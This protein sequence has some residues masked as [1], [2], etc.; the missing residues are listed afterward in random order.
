VGAFLKISIMFSIVVT[1]VSERNNIQS[2]VNLFGSCLK[3]LEFHTWKITMVLPSWAAVIC[4][5]WEAAFLF[6]PNLPP[7]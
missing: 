4:P 3:L 6:Q 2:V 7:L 1:A 5:S